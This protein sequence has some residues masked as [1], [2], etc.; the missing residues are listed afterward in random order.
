MPLAPAPPLAGA[1]TFRRQPTSRSRAGAGAERS[2]I[3]SPG[4]TSAYGPA[5]TVSRSARCVRKKCRS[6]PVL[7][8]ARAATARTLRLVA[9]S[10]PI[11]ATA[12]AM[13]LSRGPRPVLSAPGPWW[14]SDGL[15]R[16]CPALAEPELRQRQGP[17]LSR[18]QASRRVQ[19]P[20]RFP[21]PWRHHRG[22]DERLRDQALPLR[23]VSAQSPRT[24]ARRLSISAAARSASPESTASSKSKCSSNVAPSLPST[25]RVRRPRRR[26][27]SCSLQ[28]LTPLRPMGK[29]C[30][31]GVVDY[32][33][34]R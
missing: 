2:W 25:A 22:G 1:S 26:V 31:S 24:W 33:G 21:G 7:T 29:F 11:I 19:D 3:L 17:P 15:R 30:R 23:H 16:R 27:W 12:A 32:E 34:S 8:P 13:I 20:G 18:R 5:S 4:T 14:S 9:G 28:R 10:S 6:E